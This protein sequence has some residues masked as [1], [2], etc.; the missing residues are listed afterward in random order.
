VGAFS[1][2]TLM[3]V[4]IC[5]IPSDKDAAEIRSFA[6]SVLPDDCLTRLAPDSKTMP[7]ITVAQFESDSFEKIMKLIPK[8]VEIAVEL[9]G[10]SIGPSDEG[11]WIDIPIIK[12]E[13]IQKMHD[14]VVSKLN[15]YKIINKTGSEYRPHI[16]L[17]LAEKEVNL[18][19][20]LKLKP[21]LE[22]TIKCR[23]SIGEGDRYLQ[24]IRLFQS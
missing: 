17:G 24:V 6:K 4:N 5:L 23:L 11:V 3:I 12:S 8:N 13:K 9:S 1:K 10:L 14:E 19:V 21:L 7:H 16:T 22:K 20:S 15:A 18:G 2:V